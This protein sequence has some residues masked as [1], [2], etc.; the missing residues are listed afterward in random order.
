MCT[1][2]PSVILRTDGSFR[3]FNDQFCTERVAR[4]VVFCAF[5]YCEK[6]MG[7]RLQLMNIL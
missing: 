1:A 6:C 7:G 3:Q 2:G 5:V 4:M